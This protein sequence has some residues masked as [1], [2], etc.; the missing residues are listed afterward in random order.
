MYRSL[1]KSLFNV[2]QLE[3]KEIQKFV[4]GTTKHI[5]ESINNEIE[6]EL[7]LMFC[8]EGEN[9]LHSFDM[10]DRVTKYCSKTIQLQPPSSWKYFYGPPPEEFLLM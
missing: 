2:S 8:N 1:K 7:L 4:I 9:L 6:F 5:I 3:E 10:A